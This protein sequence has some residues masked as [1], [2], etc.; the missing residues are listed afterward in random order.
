[1]QKYE[2]RI[3]DSTGKGMTVSA[4]KMLVRGFDYHA[5]GKIAAPRNADHAAALLQDAGIITV[6]GSVRPFG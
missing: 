6:L 2:F 1:M 5:D 4:E 3:I